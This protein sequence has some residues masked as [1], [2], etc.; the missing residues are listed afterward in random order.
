MLESIRKKENITRGREGLAHN[1]TPIKQ[2]EYKNRISSCS[3]AS[4][5]K[6]I[7]RGGRSSTRHTRPTPPCAPRS[8]GTH[9]YDR[10]LHAV[11]AMLVV[12]ALQHAPVHASRDF[13]AVRKR[14]ELKGGLDSAAAVRV[15]ASEAHDW[16]HALHD[17]RPAQR[18]G[19]GSMG[20]KG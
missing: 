19:N 6:R 2:Y 20:G 7:S 4:E 9:M 8:L 15:E 3:K 1:P 13:Y 12:D 10:L 14:R 16:Q 17:G 11:V 18:R 5:R